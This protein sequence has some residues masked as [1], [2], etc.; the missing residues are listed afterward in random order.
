MVSR[1]EMMLSKVESWEVHCRSSVQY[2]NH[3]NF[4]LR[5]VLKLKEKNKAL[6]IGVNHGSLVGTPV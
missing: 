4:Q 2:S 1:L 3:F 6:R 5:L